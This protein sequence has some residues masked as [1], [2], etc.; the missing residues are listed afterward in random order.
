MLSPSFIGIR[1]PKGA[2][3]VEADYDPGRWTLWLF[4][5]EQLLVIAA[6]TF[7]RLRYER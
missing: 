3:H 2:H 1:V 4:L 7:E 6:F 5:L